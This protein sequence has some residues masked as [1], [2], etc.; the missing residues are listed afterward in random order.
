MNIDGPSCVP[1]HPNISSSRGWAI[2]S[3]SLLRI[4]TL[5]PEGC[6]I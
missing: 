4:S 1:T 3:R 5:P 2:K 6:S